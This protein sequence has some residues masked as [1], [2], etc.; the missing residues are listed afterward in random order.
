[1]RS[2]FAG[3]DDAAGLLPLSHAAEH[4]QYIDVGRHVIGRIFMSA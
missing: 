4:T 1:V 3:A 2:L